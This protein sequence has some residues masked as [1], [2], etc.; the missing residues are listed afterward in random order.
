MLW[1]IVR[2][3]QI[4]SIGRSH[5]PAIGSTLKMILEHCAKNPNI[6]Y[7]CITLKQDREDQDQEPDLDPG[8]P[9]QCSS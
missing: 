7:Y 5:V 6:V 3:L 8:G 9:V 2:A 4:D 1:L